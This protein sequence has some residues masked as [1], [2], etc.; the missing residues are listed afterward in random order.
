MT[1]VYLLGPGAWTCEMAEMYPAST[2]HGIDLNPVFPRN[3]QPKNVRFDVAKIGEPLAFPDNTFQLVHQRL[4][5]IGLSAADWDVV[6]RD[7]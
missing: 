6:S 7:S 1:V 3:G 2:F 5:A 4:V